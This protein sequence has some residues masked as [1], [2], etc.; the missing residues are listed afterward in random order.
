MRRGMAMRRRA[1]EAAC[2]VVGVVALALVV[3][4]C[5][6]SDNKSSGVKGPDIN[7]KGEGKLNI[8]NWEGYTDPSFVKGFEKETGCKVNDVFA[9]TS[10]EMFTKFRSGGGGQYDLASFSGD[11]SLRAI[12]SGSV[13]PLD[14]SKLTNFSDLAKQLQSPDFNTQNGKHYGLSFMWGANVLIYNAD[15]VKPAP[16]SWNVLYDPKYKGKI[17]VPDN[18][19][20]IADPA[21]QYFGASN[22]YAIDQATLN[23]VKAKL[24]QQRGLVRK[25]WVLATDFDQL[26]KSG[27]ATIG[28]GWPLMTNDLK[29]AGLNVKEVIPKEGVTGWSDSWMLSNKARHPICAYKYMNYVTRPDIQVK[30]ADVT[31]YSPANTKSCSNLGAQRCKD[32][33]V[34]D[35]HYYD[36]IKY[37]ETPTAPTN[38]RQWTDT[39]AEVKG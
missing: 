18:P 23:E 39:W 13:A 30:V 9:G 10:D 35:Q 38:Y 20:Q 17:T 21:L 7:A 8:V 3:A 1:L 24:K 16:D 32:L 2:V 22:P 25:Y 33:H 15:K 14:T 26:F 11:A 27:D 37:W 12:K 5:G 34:T 29:K 19:I 36:T 6:G 4:S 31:G 28:A